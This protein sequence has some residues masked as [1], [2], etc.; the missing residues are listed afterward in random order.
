MKKGKIYAISAIF[1]IGINVVLFVLDKMNIGAKLG[2]STNYDWLSFIGNSIAILVAVYVPLYV[3]ETTLQN[4][5]QNKLKCEKWN[6]CMEIMSDISSLIALHKKACYYS[7]NTHEREKY[8]ISCGEFWQK[9]SFIKMKLS[10]L[11]KTGKYID[12]DKL[13]DQ[14]ERYVKPIEDIT[15]RYTVDKSIQDL[16]IYEPS[17]FAANDDNLISVVEEFVELNTR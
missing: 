6:V 7:Y 3:L 5:I 12:T 13:L 10:T 11:K 2:L 9:H 15:G 16:F 4:E 1:W 17:A 14:L 8:I